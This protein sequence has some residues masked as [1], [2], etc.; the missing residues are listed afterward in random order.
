MFRDCRRRAEP[1]HFIELIVVRK[2]RLGNYAVYLTLLYN[3]GAI[4]QRTSKAERDAHYGRK[5]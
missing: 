2:I 4:K 3:C 1:T 5:V